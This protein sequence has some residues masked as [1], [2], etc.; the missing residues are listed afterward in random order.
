MEEK[1]NREQVKRCPVCF[2]AVWTFYYDKLDQKL[3]TKDRYVKCRTCGAFFIENRL[4]PQ[5]IVN[6]FYQNRRGIGSV[7]KYLE[8]RLYLVK[9]VK[10]LKRFLPKKSAVFDIGCGGGALLK[11][12]KD[13]GYNIFGLEVS[14]EARGEA[15]SVVGLKNIICCGD[16]LKL[17][18]NENFFDA[19]LMTDVV[20]HLHN[21]HIYLEKIKKILKSRGLLVIRTP[22]SD[23]FFHK[24]VKQRWILSSPRHIVIY[25]RNSLLALLEKNKFKVIYFS[26]EKYIQT[27]LFPSFSQGFN[28][29]LR[30]F[31]VNFLRKLFALIGKGES[32]TIIARKNF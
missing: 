30:G 21:P 15:E 26:R 24:L 7:E 20:E 5:F 32:I 23:C 1:E 14:E 4:N 27:N 22:N 11:F 16:F 10:K 28:N 25:N 8:K 19:V 17:D 3:E 31:A 13:C 18:F 9:V 2:S 6:K 12:M 29:F